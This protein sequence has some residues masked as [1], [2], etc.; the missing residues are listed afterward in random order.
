MVENK[1]RHSL[2]GGPFDG[3][4]VFLSASANTTLTFGLNGFYGRYIGKEQMVWTECHKELSELVITGPIYREKRAKRTLKV[5]L[6]KA[7]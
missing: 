1:I 7:A 4:I 5:T 3:N 6:G 2:H